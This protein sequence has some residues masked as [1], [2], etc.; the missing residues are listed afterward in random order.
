MFEI[1]LIS[2]ILSEISGRG[3]M[4]DEYFAFRPKHSS[5]LQL[6]CLVERVTRNCGDKR[7]TG[8]V[9]LEVAKAFD[10]IV[11]DGFLIK[12]TALNFPSYPVKTIS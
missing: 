6:A 2:R 7:L 5:S 11:V 3:L 8:A 12:L 4:C 9:F 1:I 10:T